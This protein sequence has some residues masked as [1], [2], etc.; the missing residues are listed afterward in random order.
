M[1]R[2]W[3][4][5]WSRWF[6]Y[7]CRWFDWKVL[8]VMD[9]SWGTVWYAQLPDM[10]GKWGDDHKHDSPKC[11]RIHPFS[12][13]HAALTQS[14]PCSPLCRQPSVRAVFHHGKNDEAQDWQSPKSQETPVEGVH[15]NMAV[16][17]RI[18][19]VLVIIHIVWLRAKLRVWSDKTII[20]SGV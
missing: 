1:N 10:A 2:C 19:K 6:D 18:I 4:W 5:W 14:P 15:V 16:V 7:W 11:R 13:N 3:R 20:V 9:S 8:S 17:I 12:W